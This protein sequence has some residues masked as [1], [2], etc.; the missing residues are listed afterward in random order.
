[1]RIPIRIRYK[2]TDYPYSNR[3][4]GFSRAAGIMF[5]F[6]AY[7][8]WWFMFVATIAFVLDNMCDMTYETCMWIGVVLSIP[9]IFLLR[10][11]KKKIDMII[12]KIALKDY[13]KYI[14]KNPVTDN[15]KN[16]ADMFDMYFGNKS[17]Q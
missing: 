11:L 14:A 3:A 6:V 4:T 8:W 5:S 15:Q 1:M 12:D 9:Y 13:K 7:V 10:L 2:Y 16:F 17:G